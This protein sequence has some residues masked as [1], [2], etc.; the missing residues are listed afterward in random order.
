[1]C[2]M[3]EYYK[4]GRSKKIE[5]GKFLIDQSTNDY[6]A[7]D[8]VG[9]YSPYK[10]KQL[11]KYKLPLYLDI[12]VIGDP[13]IHE[14]VFMFRIYN[15][16]QG[17]Y[18]HTNSSHKILDALM[19]TENIIFWFQDMIEMPEVS[20]DKTLAGLFKVMEPN[21]IIINRDNIRDNA[22]NDFYLTYLLQPI[23]E[24]IHFD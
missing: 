4:S 23:K 13:I 2:I 1:M 18:Y 20:E 24:E 11:K 9:L 16:V 15:E 10:V 21:A 6:I 5:P 14:F 12:G 8:I 19:H 7:F 22:L 3:C 17:L